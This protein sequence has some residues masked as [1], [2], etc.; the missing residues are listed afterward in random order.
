M[1]EN[2]QLKWTVL[3]KYLCF[4]EKKHSTDKLF[5]DLKIFKEQYE[6]KF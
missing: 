3:Q 4:D 2:M 6:V 5:G 1:W